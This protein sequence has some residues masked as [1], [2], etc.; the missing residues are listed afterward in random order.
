[1][2]YGAETKLVDVVRRLQDGCYGNDYRFQVPHNDYTKGTTCEVLVK[3]AISRADNEYIPL[4]PEVECKIGAL[5]ID[6]SYEPDRSE[7]PIDYLVVDLT[8]EDDLHEEFIIPD[9]C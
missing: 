2:H 6:E 3:K 9:R 5:T 4:C 7:I 1:M 8:K